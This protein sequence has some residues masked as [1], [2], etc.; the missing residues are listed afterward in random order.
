MTQ[1]WNAASALIS[2]PRNARQ[3]AFV[4]GVWNSWC[5]HFTWPME[6]S[7][8]NQC[9]VFS[10]EVAAFKTSSQQ[11][12]SVVLREL[13]EYV[14]ASHCPNT[15]IVVELSQCRFQTEDIE[16]LQ[17]SLRLHH[18]RIS[19]ISLSPRSSEVFAS[20]VPHDA[21]TADIG[22]AGAFKICRVLCEC[23]GFASTL[24]ELHLVCFVAFY[25]FFHAY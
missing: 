18:T 16:A 7:S 9:P 2:S 5:C 22:D 21:E 6:S 3:C 14:P 12:V 25:L 19:H 24:Q 4:A 17:R 20:A 11:S 10:A 23:Q 15:S 13:E 8:H 1:S